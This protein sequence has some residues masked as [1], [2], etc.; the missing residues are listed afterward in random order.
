MVIGLSGVQFDRTS[1]QNRT[2]AQQK[3]DLFITSMITDRIA[4]FVVSFS[5]LHYNVIQRVCEAISTLN[6]K[7]A[8]INQSKKLQFPRKEEY[9]G[10]K[11][12]IFH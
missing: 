10:M 4:L 7:I 9:Q 2:T 8:R 1:E 3:S 6:N 12:E 5:H 11:R